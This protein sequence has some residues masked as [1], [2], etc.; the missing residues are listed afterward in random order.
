MTEWPSKLVLFIERCERN[1]FRFKSPLSGRI[2]IKSAASGGQCDLSDLSEAFDVTAV[3]LRQH[4]ADLVDQGFLERSVNLQDKRRKTLRLTEAGRNLTDKFSSC[5]RLASALL[6]AGK[7]PYTTC[8][9]C[10]ARQH[11]HLVIMKREN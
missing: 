1:I 11:C 2:L 8:H 5:V 9:D 3:C 10:P 6:A 4:L 7:D